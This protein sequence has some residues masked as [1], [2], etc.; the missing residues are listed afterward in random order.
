MFLLFATGRRP[1]KADAAEAELFREFMSLNFKEEH[2]LWL[3]ESGVSLS[4]AQR[5]YGRAL[6]GERTQGTLTSGRTVNYSVLPVMSIHQ[7]H[8][9]SVVKGAFN[10]HLFLD[11]IKKV[12]LPVTTPYPGP[13]S[14]VIMDN[15]KFHH[16][17]YVPCM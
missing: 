5:K 17:R 16:C 1:R 11:F 10:Q 3:D 4:V 12:I 6:K 7:V 15:V 14:V 9:V 2:L 8:G 13:R